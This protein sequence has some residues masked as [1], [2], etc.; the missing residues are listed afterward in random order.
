MGKYMKRD[1]SDYS[2]KYID[3]GFEY[4]QVQYRRKLVSEQIDKYKPK[5]ILEIG[6]GMEPLFVHFP[7]IEFTIIEPSVP[8]CGHAKELVQQTGCSNVKIIN[9]FFGDNEES[10]R[11]DREFDMIVCSSLLHEVGNPKEILSIISKKCNNN[12]IVHINVPNAYSLHRLLA[13][14]SGMIESVYEKSDRNILLQQNTVFDLESLGRMITGCG[15]DVIEQGSY[16]VKFFPHEAMN[17]LVELGII[18][19]QILDGLYNLTKYI[20]EF[21]SEIYVNCRLKS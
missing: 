2:D 14:T 11:L 20:P 19:E 10:N 7:K 17:R 21:G 16:F 18:T 12:T 6:C 3:Y 4:Y 8:F 15:F 5:R 1:I 13:E 9:A